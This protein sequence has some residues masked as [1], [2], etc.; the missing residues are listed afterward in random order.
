MVLPEQNFVSFQFEDAEITN[1]K[2]KRN[3]PV[4]R[5]LVNFGFVI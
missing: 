3:V 4:N 1:P 2:I 5:S